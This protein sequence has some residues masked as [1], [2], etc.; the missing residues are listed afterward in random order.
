[1]VAV[2]IAVPGVLMA[3]LH[4]SVKGVVVALVAAEFVLASLV[5]LRGWPQIRGQAD[6]V[7]T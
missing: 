1:V 3:S 5:W 2:F 7:A 4:A 6:R